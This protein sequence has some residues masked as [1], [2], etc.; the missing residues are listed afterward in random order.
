MICR[1]AQCLLNQ[2]TC[3]STTGSCH[4]NKA[5]LFDFLTMQ[6]SSSSMKVSHFRTGSKWFVMFNIVHHTNSSRQFGCLLVSSS[7]SAENFSSGSWREVFSSG[8]VWQSRN[9]LL[10]WIP[11]VCKIF[12]TVSDWDLNLL[13]QTPTLEF[14]LTKWHQI[15]TP[16][17]RC[18]SLHTVSSLSHFSQREV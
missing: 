2:M 15:Q 9:L 3:K 5:V 16:L 1:C 11:H 8:N 14:L 7:F 17:L 4:R 18:T 10:F 12:K 13:L 6:Y